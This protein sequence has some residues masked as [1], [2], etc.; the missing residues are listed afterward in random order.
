MLNVKRNGM[1]EKL[2]I[3]SLRALVYFANPMLFSSLDFNIF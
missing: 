2:I 1:L 3:G